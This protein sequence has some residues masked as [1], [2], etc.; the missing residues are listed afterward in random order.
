M[1]GAKNMPEEERKFDFSVLKAS[2]DAE[3][4]EM[5]AQMDKDGWE[6]VTLW[7][8][9]APNFKPEY[10]QVQPR[11]TILPPHSGNPRGIFI[12]CAGGAFIFKSSNEARPVAE[13]FRKAGLN[14]AILDYRVQPY[15]Q[16]DACEDAKRAI[17]TLRFNAKKYNILP[18]KIAIGGFSAGGMLT[19][20]AAT[21][22]DYGNPNASDPIER[23]SSRPDAAL[24][25]YGSF[26]AAAGGAGGLGYDVEKQN[27]KARLSSDKSLRHDSPPF[28]LFQTAKD[29]P[30]NAITMG[31]ELADLGIPF[32]IHIFKNG[33]HGNGLYDG[34]FGVQDVPHTAHWSMLAVEWLEEMGF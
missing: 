14:T 11:L 10:G 3:W 2:R 25:L 28:F 23:V 32:E 4:A 30:R 15:T 20:L 12:I 29:D 22:F 27:E 17:R 18:E 16:L 7:P 24:Q 34:K 9:G 26:S 19:G 13:Y 1:K 8:E 21:M 5:Y 33:S 31:K 6:T